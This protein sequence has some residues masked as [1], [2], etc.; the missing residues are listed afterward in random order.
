M[1]SDEASS[2]EEVDSSLEDDTFR[3][4]YSM[5]ELVTM[6]ETV[7]SKLFDKKL[8]THVKKRENESKPSTKS[9]KQADF[10]RK[11]KNRPQEISSKRPV[12]KTH[13]SSSSKL[14][15]RDP[16]FDQICGSEFDKDVFEARFSFLEGMRTRE[17]RL[18]SRKLK[19][20]KDPQKRESLKYLIQ[21]MD[22]QSREKERRNEERE[23]IRKWHREEKGKVAEGKKPYFLKDSDK[24][25]MIQEHRKK[26]KL[27]KNQS[28]QKAK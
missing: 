1:S 7:G 16:R 27:D 14:S 15:T 25:K 26:K 9:V 2:A 18:L 6:R 8:A 10:I 5:E 20:T 21:R 22:N 12:R 4:E 24:K 11:N 28:S 19:K 23:V 3:G 13:G 17:K